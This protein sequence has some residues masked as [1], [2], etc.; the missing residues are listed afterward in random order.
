[1][2]LSEQNL[3]ETTNYQ[4]HDNRGNSGDDGGYV[5]A[6]PIVRYRRGEVVER[7]NDG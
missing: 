1:M 5:D 4:E 6:E 7:I 2:L 3:E